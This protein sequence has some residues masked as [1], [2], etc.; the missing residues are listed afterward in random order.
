MG[1]G[2]IVEQHNAGVARNT[3]KEDEIVAQTSIIMVA[4]Q[5]TTANTLA[6]SLLELAKDP[7]LQENLRAEIHATVGNARAS[8]VAY[9]NMPLLNAFIKVRPFIFPKLLWK[10]N[11]WWS[12]R[13]HSG[14]TPASRC[15]SVLPFKTPLFRSRMASGRQTANT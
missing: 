3:L 2:E 10:L 6:F 1:H 12:N 5:D 4:G 14:C 9:D 7:E 8:S 11:G 13:R 15:R